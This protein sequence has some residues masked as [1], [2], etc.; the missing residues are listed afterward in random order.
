M[1]I[2]K[3]YI[4]IIFTSML[5]LGISFWIYV[6]KTIQSTQSLLICE[7]YQSNKSHIDQQFT[8]ALDNQIK[9]E[10]N[11][12]SIWCFPGVDVSSF[13][14]LWKSWF[15]KDKNFIYTI[16]DIWKKYN[17]LVLIKEILEWIDVNTFHLDLKYLTWQVNKWF[18][19]INDRN[20]IYFYYTLSNWYTSL[21]KLQNIDPITFEFIKKWNYDKTL[22]KIYFQD[23]N[24]LYFAYLS[25]KWIYYKKVL[26]N[27]I[28]I[29]NT[30][31]YSDIIIDTWEY[32]IREGKI[33][34]Y[35]DY[36]TL[37]WI[38]SVK[39]YQKD[40]NNVYDKNF[41]IIPN[42]NPDKTVDMWHENKYYISDG[43]YF[44]L[45]WQ[46]ETQNSNWYEYENVISINKTPEL[47]SMYNQ[48]KSFYDN[49]AY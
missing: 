11:F 49:W 29:S 17:E 15:A 18:G 33:L 13:E 47:I 31:Y 32:I 19:I 28:D 12:F 42:L 26:N 10:N 43:N 30:Y 1:K 8:Y 20:A 37:V 2:D 22:S 27:S 48:M 46:R 14:L 21:N 6:F 39:E 34:D 44:Y 5:L 16:S 23:K 4:K 24:W 3:K 45:T 38:W 25:Q 9:L 36:K 41:D 40:K 7:N 35:I